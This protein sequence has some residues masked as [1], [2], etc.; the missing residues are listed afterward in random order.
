[1]ITVRFMSYCS[2][3]LAYPEN[4]FKRK[5][6]LCFLPANCPTFCFPPC[7]YFGRDASRP[8][9]HERGCMRYKRHEGDPE[10]GTEPVRT[11]SEE[12]PASGTHH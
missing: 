4:A 2:F 3:A 12:G 8:G 7:S 5:M 11:A 6:S 9:Q 10:S 1:M